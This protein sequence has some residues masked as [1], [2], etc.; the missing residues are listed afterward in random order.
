VRRALPAACDIHRREKLIKR[1]HPVILSHELR[2]VPR[3]NRASISVPR[4]KWIKFQ[5]KRQQEF[6]I[7]GYIP[8]DGFLRSI[9][10]GHYE[11]GKLVF[12]GKVRGGFGPFNRKELAEKLKPFETPECPV[13]QSKNC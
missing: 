12:A 8:E 13:P 2:A 5:L 1:S 6:V 11:N 3:Q 4:F 9:A 7:G 10:V